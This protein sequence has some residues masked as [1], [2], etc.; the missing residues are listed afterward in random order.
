MA[1][2]KGIVVATNDIGRERRL[3]TALGSSGERDLVP[4]L[5]LKK[6]NV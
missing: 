4:L 5:F 2:A 3:L 1:C 6:S